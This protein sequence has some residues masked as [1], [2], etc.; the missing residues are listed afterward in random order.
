[1]HM[2]AQI[3]N[4]SNSQTQKTGC[5]SSGAAKG[6]KGSLKGTKSITF[7]ISRFNLR[8]HTL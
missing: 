1:M 5:E 2:R 3:L 6:L 7:A 4:N 8:L